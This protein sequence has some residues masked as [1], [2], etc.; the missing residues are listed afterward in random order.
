MTSTLLKMHGPRSALWELSV[1]NSKEL[2]RN[3]KSVFA[4]L[5]TF[6]LLLLVFAGV[7]GIVFGNRPDPVVAVAGSS[8][9]SETLTNALH[10]AG[11]TTG[12]VDGAP[13]GSATAVVTLSS[14]SVK[15]V[16]AATH[17][18][19]WLHLVRV[20]H[21]TLGIPSANIIVVDSTGFPETDMF[22]NSLGAVLLIG[23]A[24]VAFAGVS[25]SLVALRQRG[26][27]KLLGTT[28]VR[29][30]TFIV[31]QTPVQF[32][33]GAAEALIIVVLA[34]TLGYV[35]SLSV[36]RLLVTLLLGLGMLFA[37]AYL[38]AA[39]A[40]DSE[41]LSQL[42]V[43]FPLVLVFTSGAIMPFAAFPPVVRIVLNLIPTTWFSEAVSVDIAGAKPVVSVYL[44][45]LF[46]AVTTLVIGWLA[47]RPFVWDQTPR[48]RSKRVRPGRRTGKATAVARAPRT[49]L[50]E[51]SV[52]S[53]KELVRSSRQM[54]VIVV[55]FASFLVIAIIAQ[56]VLTSSGTTG[57]TA[58]I[59]ILKASLPAVLALGLT[60]I[61]FTGT[62]V[63]LVNLRRRGILRLFGTTPLKRSVFIAS[64]AP[65]R[66]VLGILELLI[67][68][69]IAWQ[70][71]YV[72]LGHL[73]RLAVSVLLG[74]SMLLSLGYLLGSRSKNV[75]MVEQISAFLPIFV[76]ATSGVIIPLGFF[77]DPVR[78]VFE[79][80]PT[81]WF[82][83]AVSSD[84]T[85][86]D[87]SISVYN[88]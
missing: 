2:L 23:Y 26:M 88:L 28:P 14:D 21:D 73:P 82:M 15:V 25:V 1:T 62:S 10:S 57:K 19:T 41:A 45:W 84:L 70:Q 5:F 46:M 71:G 8:T 72:P 50:L 49:A 69:A 24:G 55:S 22:R 53:A 17:T 42:V 63:P 27:L 66:F 38:L 4:V 39:W 79:G 75:G 20:I 37:F 35:D 85:G 52:A 83:Q 32:L 78:I 54:L 3:G 6:V 11:I 29:R 40:K 44:L 30:L 59:D 18:P 51:L 7:Q 64:Q 80:L 60:A 86:A 65:T 77:P 67:V 47:A 12:A 13:G 31:S 74:F 87:T 43:M 76:I 36:L 56:L 9:Q 61:A 81:T 48:T 68:L 16:V 34:A 33:I 58:G